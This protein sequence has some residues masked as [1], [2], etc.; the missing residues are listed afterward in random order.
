MISKMK[1][2]DYFDRVSAVFNLDLLENETENPNLLWSSGNATTSSA[3]KKQERPNMKGHTK[4]ELDDNDKI[5]TISSSDLLSTE[6]RALL[7]QIP[8]ALRQGKRV[9]RNIDAEPLESISVSIPSK[10]TG[11]YSINEGE[12]QVQ[13]QGATS[14][15]DTGSSSRFDTVHSIALVVFG[16]LLFAIYKSVA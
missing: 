12:D 10:V 14:T 13:S 1:A 15:I 11:R 7:L 5:E 8:E 9:S 4:Q 6:E 16:F 3:G 2:K